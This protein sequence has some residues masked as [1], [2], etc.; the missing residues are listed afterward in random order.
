[1]V[2]K[3]SLQDDSLHRNVQYSKLQRL[4]YFKEQMDWTITALNISQNMS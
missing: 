3:D 1:M 2:C 4:I